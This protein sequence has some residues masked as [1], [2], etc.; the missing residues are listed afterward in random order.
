MNKARKSFGTIVRLSVPLAILISS[1]AASA[2]LAVSGLARLWGSPG[3]IT[4]EAIGNIAHFVAYAFAWRNEGVAEIWLA[5][6]AIMTYL[7]IN[8][9]PLILGCL[10]VQAW[11]LC[12]EKADA[13]DVDTTP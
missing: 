12:H 1:L 6:I 7:L 13:D 9:V 2:T 8:A 4:T 11:E 10:A 3:N 5:P